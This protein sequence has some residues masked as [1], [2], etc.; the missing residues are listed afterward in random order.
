MSVNF[1]KLNFGKNSVTE[2][3]HTTYTLSD[4]VQLGMKLWLP[5]SVDQTSYFSSLLTG[6]TEKLSNPIYSSEGSPFGQKFPCILEY[7]PYAKDSSMTLSRDHQRHPWMCSHGYVVLRVDLRGTGSSGG[8]YYGEYEQAEMDD[9]I[10][11]INWLSVQSWSNGCIGMYGKSWGGYNGLQMAYKQPEALKTTISLYLTDNRATDDVHHQ[12]NTLIPNGLL[13]WSNFMYA[14]NARPPHPKY[15][16][17]ITAWKRF[18]LDRLENSCE[19][20]LGDWLAHQDPNDSFWKHGSVCHD[21]DKVK[22]PML[23]IGGLG[24]AYL[25][26]ILRMAGKLNDASRFIMGP[27]VH[28]WPDVSVCGPNID[29]LQL[30][31]SWWN[32]HLKPEV[33]SQTLELPRLSFYL[34]DS[35]LANE[36]FSDA[37]GKWIGFPNWQKLLSD[38]EKATP[39]S[40][41]NS[42]LRYLYISS[43][44]SVEYKKPTVTADKIELKPHA[45]QG[46]NCGEWFTS[47][48]GLP[49]D[50]AQANAYSACWKS[51][52]LTN[53]FV[54]AGFSKFY[55]CISAEKA[56]S[57]NLQVRICD[58]FE[59]GEST[60]ITKGCLNL[61]NHENGWVGHFSGDETIFEIGLNCTGY[62]VKPGHCILISISPNYYPM[63]YPAINNQGLFVHPSKSC[64]IIQ[65]TVGE[66]SQP[67]LPFDKPK[68][69]L[70][71][72]CETTGEHKLQMSSEKVDHNSYL[73][74]TTSDEGMTR[75]PHLG[76]ECHSRTE[77]KYYTDELVTYASM[78]SINTIESN[79]DI[80]NNEKMKTFIEAYEEI[81]GDDRH[82]RIKEHL[83]VSMNGEMLV[84]KKNTRI[85]PRKYV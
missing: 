19:S 41:A 79:F 74:K 64:L 25:N 20:F 8:Y 50:Q 27:W 54:F 78:D 58:E 2:V 17:D 4:G 26:A 83:K 71:L 1:E 68:P 21:Y 62:T 61:C 6:D 81:K 32:Q 5:S 12:G 29:F 77:E 28:D 35:H 70:E 15:F 36:V 73:F 80:G 44:M 13:S 42:H 52:K 65:S 60:L 85:I 30:C 40:L 57:F 67:Y 69:L 47:D 34:K 45:L 63:M 76:Y 51:E 11:L 9:C 37:V 66:E 16:N 39:D 48:Y 23:I 84:E 18:W 55:V 31:L 82:F 33:Q 46:V 38:Y 7:L 43:S 49:G 3:E 10:E 72:D 75:F 56:G 24:D 22:I 53:D 14:I 59:S